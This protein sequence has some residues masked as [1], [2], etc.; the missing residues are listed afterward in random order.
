MVL[1]GE[2]AKRVRTHALPDTRALPTGIIILANTH[3]PPQPQP[4]AK[5]EKNGTAT[6]QPQGME[7]EKEEKTYMMT[8][9]TILHLTP[10]P[11]RAR[12]QPRQKGNGNQLLFRRPVLVLKHAG[13]ALG[14]RP[15]QVVVVA[16]LVVVAALLDVVEGRLGYL[17]GRV[18]AAGAGVPFWVGC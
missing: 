3:S 16:E 13:G 18:D 8:I 10:L 15:A 2:L 5:I 14:A 17:E 4:E 9:N 11:V 6:I 7:K 1:L 12:V